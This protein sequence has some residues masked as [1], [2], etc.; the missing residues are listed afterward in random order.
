MILRDTA[1]S[2]L[3]IIIALIIVLILPFALAIFARTWFWLVD[4]NPLAPVII[5]YLKAAKR[6]L[7]WAVED[8]P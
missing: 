4:H 5:W 1:M 2:A 3:I 7:D 6:A 8:R